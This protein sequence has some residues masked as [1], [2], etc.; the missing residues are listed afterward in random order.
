[1]ARTEEEWLTCG[2]TEAMLNAL[3]D[4]A[5]DRKLRLFACAL[6]RRLA[7]LTGVEQYARGLDAAEFTADGGERTEMRLCR[8]AINERLTAWFTRE[9]RRRESTIL[10]VGHAA[11]SENEFRDITRL[12]SWVRTSGRG[13]ALRA[14]LAESHRVVSDIFGNPFRPVTL[15]PSWLTSTVVTLA[16]Q[17]YD[18][19][20]FTAMPILA[21]AL[22]DAGCA[23]DQVMTHCRGEGPHVRGCW[24][25]D[26]C[27]GKA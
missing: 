10:L 19:R 25:V 18:S 12:L 4:K 22:Q 3:R 15:D 6:A 20:D 17:M 24:V 2:D 14:E 16:R 21:D 5:G 23:D 11:M 1:L 9:D 7:S 27:R 26:Q 8:R 13:D